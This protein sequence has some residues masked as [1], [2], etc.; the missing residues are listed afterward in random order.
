M[1]AK[2]LVV[3]AL[4]V[5]CVRP[6]FAQ[7]PE[8]AGRE[9]ATARIAGLEDAR[10]AALV[11]GDA[12]ALGRLFDRDAT[13]VHSNGLIQTREE[14]IAMLT[15]G[16]IRYVSF[17]VDAVQY[18]WYGST[19]VGTGVQTIELTASGT[20]FTSRSRFTVVY[21]TDGGEPRVVAY[22][23]THLSEVVKEERR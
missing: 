6:G 1:K 22:Q 20:P 9:D 5:S 4:V 3:A 15:R 14:L 18:R 23:S 2:L 12:E 8:P 21:A 19:V 7:P 13:Y 17:A 11:R 10:R 16:E